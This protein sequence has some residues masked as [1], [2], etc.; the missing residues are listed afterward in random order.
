[1]LTLE[2]PPGETAAR[3]RFLEVRRGIEDH[4]CAWFAG[5]I[6]VEA[7]EHE[8]RLPRALAQTLIAFTD[9]YFLGAQIDSSEPPVTEFV[10]LVVDILSAATTRCATAAGGTDPRRLTRCD[11]STDGRSS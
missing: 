3:D 7:V 11:G 2:Q 4:I 5:S 1:M 10:D 6:P 9:G 8:P